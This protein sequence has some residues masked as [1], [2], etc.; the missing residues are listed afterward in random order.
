MKVLDPLIDKKQWPILHDAMAVAIPYVL[1]GIVFG[2]LIRMDLYPDLGKAGDYV[3]FVFT[4][5]AGQIV[6]YVGTTPWEAFM[7]SINMIVTVFLSWL[8]IAPF[9][10]LLHA[11]RNK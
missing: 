6:S 3:L 5:V 7:L 9:I 11:I 10:G 1:L 4:P 8:C 2:V